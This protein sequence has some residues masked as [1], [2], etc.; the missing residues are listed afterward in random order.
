MARITILQNSRDGVYYAA[1]QVI[2]EQG[3]VAKEMFVIQDGEVEILVDGEAVDV[4]DA[5]QAFGEM[6]LVD[7]KPR[8]G[9]ARARTDCRVVPVDERRFLFMVQETPN[10]AL[11]VM[12]LMADRLR[13]RNGR[14]ET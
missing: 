2:F 7:R 12:G 13:K 3:D 10:F 6:A 11:Q 8:S 5:G 14:P 1:G 4:L 9:T